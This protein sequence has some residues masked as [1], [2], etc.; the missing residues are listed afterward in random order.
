LTKIPKAQQPMFK[1]G[2]SSFDL[3]VILAS[4]YCSENISDKFD[5]RRFGSFELLLRQSPFVYR[6]PVLIGMIMTLYCYGKF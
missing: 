2:T 6:L 4:M 1:V 3:P 5:Y